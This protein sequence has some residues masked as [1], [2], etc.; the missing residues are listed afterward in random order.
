PPAVKPRIAPS[1][2]RASTA[3]GVGSLTA[4][5][6][7]PAPT[8]AMPR[9]CWTRMAHTQWRTCVMA[10]AGMRPAGDRRRHWGDGRYWSVTACE[11]IHSRLARGKLSDDGLRRLDVGR[12]PTRGIVET[13]H[14]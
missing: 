1:T 9:S 3:S 10:E 5:L 6:R 12:A 13:L 11:R 14:S 2:L 7:C 8:S 4:A